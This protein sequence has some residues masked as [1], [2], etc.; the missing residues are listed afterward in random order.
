MLAG[1][2]PKS[3]V[4]AGMTAVPCTE[5]HWANC[6]YAAASYSMITNCEWKAALKAPKATAI[7]I[8]DQST[9]R[10]VGFARPSSRVPQ[11]AA[12]VTEGMR[13]QAYG[14]INAVSASQPAITGIGLK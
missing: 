9:Q 6:M 12:P 7:A 5:I 4:L 1:W 2:P 13:R 10:G 11:A 3:W 14:T 8:S